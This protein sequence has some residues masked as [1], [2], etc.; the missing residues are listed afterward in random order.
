MK[1]CSN[2][3]AE[4]HDE[5]VVC[6]KCGCELKG[7]K[8]QRTVS[9]NDTMQIVIKVFLIMGCI[10]QGWLI[11]PLAWCLP[12]T[13]SVFNSFKE[14]KPI[15]MGTKICVLLFVNMIAGIFLLC[16]KDY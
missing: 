16:S 14:G 11:L 1:Y 7:Q 15:G 3:G 8:Q 2:C 10:G 4:A 12:L 9:D 6:V 5:A 13:I